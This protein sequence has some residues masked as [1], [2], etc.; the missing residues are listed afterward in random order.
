M[1]ALCGVPVAPAVGTV[2]ASLCL[3]GTGCGVMRVW[4]LGWMHVS[5]PGWGVSSWGS[6]SVG[7]FLMHVCIRWF[8]AL[9]SGCLCTPYHR[10]SLQQGMVGI[11]IAAQ[12][13]AEN[14]KRHTPRRRASPQAWT[15][16]TERK[17][18]SKAQSSRER[19][20]AP[21]NSKRNLR[22]SMRL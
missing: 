16:I 11:G 1:G 8:A 7:R 10:I 19:Q 3:G 20:E 5:R 18:N 17:H 15:N 9:V 14:S 12:T 21:N 22:N 2:L 13:T 6:G 4:C